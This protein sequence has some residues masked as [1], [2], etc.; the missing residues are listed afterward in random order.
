MKRYLSVE[1]KKN[2]TTQQFLNKKLKAGDKIVLC[3]KDCKTTCF[4]GGYKTFNGVNEDLDFALLPV[5]YAV[6]KNGEMVRRRPSGDFT[7]THFFHEILW[8][9]KC[10]PLRF[11]VTMCMRGNPEEK[12]SKVIKAASASDA[13]FYMHQAYFHEGWT[14][15]GSKKLNE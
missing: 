5:F 7:T 15:V 2:M 9:R 14:V 13:E 3:T 6:G 1:L 4:F 12:F 8:V 10:R 11:R